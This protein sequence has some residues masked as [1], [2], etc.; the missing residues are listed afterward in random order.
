M[1]RVPYDKI[2]SVQNS[3]LLDEQLS[4]LQEAVNALKEGCKNKLTSGNIFSKNL[5]DI[6]SASRAINTLLVDNNQETIFTFYRYQ[7]YA[8]YLNKYKT[9]KVISSKESEHLIQYCLT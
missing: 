3:E 2:I 4:S 9:M 1:Y 7:G 5:K 8:D 6:K